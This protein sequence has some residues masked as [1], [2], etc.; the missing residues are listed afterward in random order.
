MTNAGQ[1]PPDPHL[2]TDIGLLR[3]D[4]V[5][6]AVPDLD[7]A[8]ALHTGTFGLRVT[9]R[10]T[11]AEQGVHEAMLTA[12]DGRTVVQLVAPADPESTLATFLG[13]RGPGLHHLAY[14]VADVAAAAATLRDRGL[15]VLY[16]E[17]RGGTSGSRITFVHPADTGGV[18]VELVEHPAGD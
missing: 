2:T 4:H 5:G 16:D 11:N 17:P 1:T 3:V 8:I 9:H 13:R 15:R 14:T 18:L 12:G 10:E 7:A 6:V